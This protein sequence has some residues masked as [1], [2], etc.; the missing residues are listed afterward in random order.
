MS[1]P[2]SL[3]VHFRKLSVTIKDKVCL[4]PVSGDVNA[5]ELVALMGPTGCGKTTLL[6]AICCRGPV[7]AGDVW[8][9]EGLAWSKALRRYVAF[10][11]QD[12]LV[13]PSLTVRQSLVF[14]ARLRLPGPLA[15]KERRVDAILADLRL[16]LQV[17]LTEA[18]HCKK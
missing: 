3:S 6:N 18:G 14:S 11:E 15:D 7:T 17:S 5:G 12:D 2:D 16:E 1:G 10:V 9:G 13:Y 8:Y 4:R